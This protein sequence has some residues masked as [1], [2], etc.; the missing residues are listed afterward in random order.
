MKSRL[1]IGVFDSGLGGLTVL[2]SLLDHLG[3]CDYVYLGDTA[4]L[5]YGSKSAQTIQKYSEQNLNFLDSQGV[6]LMVVACNSASAHW[7]SPVF[8]GKPVIT[9]IEPTLKMAL[10]KFKSKKLGVLATRAT[11]NSQAYPKTLNRLDP[12]VQIEVQAAPLLVP[13]AEEGLF[14]DPLTNLVT[15][16]YVQP[17]VSK[18]VDSLILGCTH[19]PLLRKSL[20]RAAQN[21]P[22]IES[23]PAV[24]QVLMEEH[25]CLKKENS[26]TAKIDIYLS[27]EPGHFKNWAEKILGPYEAQTWNHV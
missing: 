24:A 10:K 14:D 25:Q 21:I 2:K 6:D 9:V 13:F 3:D 15:Y 16:R 22:L 19:Y 1:K 4:R 18:G 12:E 17:L 23:G 26:E 8:N 5:P 11:L 20:E 7:S 27:D